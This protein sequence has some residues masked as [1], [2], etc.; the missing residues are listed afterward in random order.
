MRP[1]RGAAGISVRTAV[2]ERRVELIQQIAVGSVDFHSVVAGLPGLE[3]RCGKSVPHPADVFFRHG[4]GLF[5]LAVGGSR[6]GRIQDGAGAYGFQPGHGL[7]GSTAGVAQLGQDGDPV[8]MDSRCKLLQ[9]CQIRRFVKS[10]LVDAGPAFRGDETVFLDDQGRPALGHIPIVIHKS[11]G[12]LA[13]IGFFRSHGRQYQT[14]FQR[15]GTQLDGLVEQGMMHNG[16]PPVIVLDTIHYTG[17]PG[18]K[19]EEPGHPVRLLSPS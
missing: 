7:V 14:V 8:F 9:P 6:P 10:D 16:I 19:Q 13:L 3:G 15:Q 17:E 2:G 4:T 5:R 18:E 1:S 12:H 11:L